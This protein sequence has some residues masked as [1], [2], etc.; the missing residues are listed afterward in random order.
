MTLAGILEGAVL[1]SCDGGCTVGDRRCCKQAVQRSWCHCAVSKPGMLDIFE[2]RLGDRKVGRGRRTCRAYLMTENGVIRLISGP[3]CLSFFLNTAVTTT[4]GIT[5]CRF[6]L[7]GILEFHD[8]GKRDCVA[9]MEL[10]VSWKITIF[11]NSPL[12][13]DR[14][15]AR[16]FLQLVV[17]VDLRIHFAHRFTA[18][19]WN[20]NAVYCFFLVLI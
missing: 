15:V 6:L 14:Y 8:G 9:N 12:L 19:K 17:K 18:G 7:I 11:E 16:H 2:I 10:V 5:V 3:M 1:C 13:Y 4:L 20:P